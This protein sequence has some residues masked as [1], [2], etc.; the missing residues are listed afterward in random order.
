MSKLWQT[1]KWFVSP[2][3]YLDE[4][5]K[6]FAFPKK[7]KIHD[8]T[9]RDGEQEAGIELQKDEKVRVAELLAEAGVHRIEAGMPAVSKQDEAAIREIVKRKLGPEIYAF[10]RCMID[11][12]K[13]A[14][15]CGVD[16]V[17]VEIP[18]SRHLIQSAYQ[19]PLQRAVDDSIKATRYAKEQGLKTTFFTIDAT[20]E[21]LDWLIGLIKRV[22]TEGHMDSLV[23]VDTM[24]VCMPQAI[25]YFVRRMKAAIDK[26]LEAHFHND[27]G[28]GVANTLTALAN[29][30]EVAHTTVCGIGERSG[31]ASLEDVAVALLTLYGVDIGIKT[32]KLTKLCR[33]VM[34]LTGHRLPQNK[35]IV[36][37]QLFAI[38]SG[39]VSAWW[40]VCKDSAPT[41]VFPLHYSLM[42]Q[43]PPR[44]VLGKG[45]GRPSIQHWL[46]RI[47]VKATTEQVDQLLTLVKDKSLEK[48]GLLTEDEFRQLAKKVVR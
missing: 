41:E 45:S 47:G 43:E 2:W 6:G 20:R 44:V 12:V 40:E 15:D 18:S 23:L 30:A 8:T 48:K 35:S 46:D 14:A 25:E 32:E 27:F 29:G 9:L 34:Q 38:E 33:E 10:C 16:G 4:V 31:G 3:N 7:I 24:G 39:I 19:W 26:P 11:D 42:G 28:L 21:D 17:V 5:R 36:G 13:R 1:D 22:A 37:D